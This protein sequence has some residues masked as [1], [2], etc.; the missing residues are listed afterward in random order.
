MGRKEGE[1]RRRIA[2]FLMISLSIAVQV[3][4]RTRYVAP[5]PAGND[6]ANGSSAAP[7]LTL[8]HA[9]DSARA[10]DT[11]IVRA[12]T[13]KG[14]VLGWDNPQN[15]TPTKPVLFKAEPGAII[16]DRNAKTADGIN[17][18]GASYIIIDGFTV[19]N[20]LG[21]ITRAGMRAV[22]D[23]GAVLRNNVIDSCGT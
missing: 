12:G 20:T 14:F 16:N 23:T 6:A 4:G 17:L 9:A 15:G 7:W 22:T 11:T 2:V 21:T 1:M 18:E 13:Y 5:A 8:Q 19:K 3:S 10:G